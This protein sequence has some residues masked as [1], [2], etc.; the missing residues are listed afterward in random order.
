MVNSLCRLSIVRAQGP[1]GRRIARLRGFSGN[2]H[3][4]GDD[5]LECHPSRASLGEV[6][7]I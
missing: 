7:A 5:S 2:Q 6:L 1:T 3:K 4:I